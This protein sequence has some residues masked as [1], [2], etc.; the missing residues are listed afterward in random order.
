MRTKVPADNVGQSGFQY[1]FVCNNILVII[2]ATVLFKLLAF[3]H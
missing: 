3:E 1:D 2:T